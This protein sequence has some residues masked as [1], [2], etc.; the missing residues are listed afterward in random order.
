[1]TQLRLGGIVAQFDQGDD[2]RA[3]D[4]DVGD[5]V[6]ELVKIK[7]GGIILLAPNT[8]MSVEGFNDNMK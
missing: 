8:I 2:A 3:E 4:E 7:A 6:P 1:M 5:G